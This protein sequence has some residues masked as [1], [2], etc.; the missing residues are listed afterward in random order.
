MPWRNGG[1]VTQEIA[2]REDGN[3][4]LLWRLSTARVE[5]NTEYSKFPGLE[6]LSAVVEGAGVHL[7]KDGSDETIEIGPSEIGK[8]S[9]DALYH[10]TLIGGGIRHLNLIYDPRRVD[11]KML[12]IGAGLVSV[13][14]KTA[15]AFYCLE[16]EISGEGFATA[17]PGD[18]LF[19]EQGRSIVLQEGSSALSISITLK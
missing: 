3:G 12:L 1:G 2:K 18:V 13:H 14:P 16:G 8:L 15:H 9:G 4:N 7:T 10:G 11:A 19:G 17:L 6:R 5:N